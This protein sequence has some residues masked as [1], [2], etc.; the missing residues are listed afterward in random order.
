MRLALRS[1]LYR[2]SS[3]AVALESNME[4]ATDTRAAAFIC[5][6]QPATKLRSS[7][8]ACIGIGH[9]L[10]LPRLV[11]ESIGS[12]FSEEDLAFPFRLS[13]S[14]SLEL[15]ELASVWSSSAS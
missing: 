10:V 12:A 6:G 13:M 8:A 3:A 2:A 14:P 11:T 7:V 4:V 15:R 9:T 1:S 5:I